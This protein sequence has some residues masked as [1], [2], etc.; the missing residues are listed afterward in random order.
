MKAWSRA[1]ANQEREANLYHHHKAE[2]EL[3]H[4]YLH[5]QQHQQAVQAAVAAAA[6]TQQQEREQIPYGVP[7]PPPLVPSP[8][9]VVEDHCQEEHSPLPPPRSSSSSQGRSRGKRSRHTGASH[10]GGH[11]EGGRRAQSQQVSDI[12]YPKYELYGQYKYSQGGQQQVECQYQTK[13]GEDCHF[14]GGAQGSR[15]KSECQYNK[16]WPKQHYQDEGDQR[17]AV[18]DDQNIQYLQELEA[19]EAARLMQEEQ[20]QQQQQQQQQRDTRGYKKR[21]EQRQHYDQRL[22][23]KSPGTQE[24]Y[25]SLSA[26]DREYLVST[27]GSKQ[28]LVQQP[29]S[30]SQ[31]LAQQSAT[32]S[33]AAQDPIPAIE[34]VGRYVEEAKGQKSVKELAKD[35]KEQKEQKEAVAD[36]AKTSMDQTLQT[37]Q[38]QGAT[39]GTHGRQQEVQLQQEHIQYIDNDCCQ[40]A[41]APSVTAT[42]TV[43]PQDS[44]QSTTMAVGQTSTIKKTGTVG[45]TGTIGKTST[46]PS[47]QQFGT[48]ERNMAEVAEQ[49]RKSQQDLLRS[50]ATIDRRNQYGGRGGAAAADSCDTCDAPLTPAS[51]AGIDHRDLEHRPLTRSVTR[52]T[53]YDEPPEK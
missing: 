46:L 35:I 6:T 36:T 25:P 3:I 5:S 22:R 45:R 23:E 28:H 38:P 19:A 42:S 32:Q 50:T 8:E 51:L 33:K 12:H 30:H 49:N 48:L 16:T 29:Q 18:Q 9:Y 7:I 14:S 2:A 4:S 39:T 21:K 47:T 17:C 1:Q 27:V 24:T 31:D 15:T 40:V 52:A 43:I 41:V 20:Q 53:V 26:K 37:F 44:N 10:G 11:H 34:E 13:Y